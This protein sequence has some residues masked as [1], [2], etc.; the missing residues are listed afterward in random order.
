MEQKRMRSD[1]EFDVKSTGTQKTIEAIPA[2]ES[3]SSELQ[4]IVAAKYPGTTLTVRR[5]EGIPAH[6]AIQQL[7]LHIDWHAV[8]AAAEK[9]AA[10]FATT[11]F[12]KLMKAQF[13]NVFVK[14]TDS[15]EQ[16]SSAGV[17]ESTAKAKSSNKPHGKKNSSQK[18]RKD[19][20]H[21]SKARRPKHGR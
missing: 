16:E 4:G 12:L 2:I 5:R 15:G 7:L 18:V 8:A 13:R 1:I 6:M 20:S 9:A 3:L 10:A 14:P 17:A 21:K 11:E 19:I